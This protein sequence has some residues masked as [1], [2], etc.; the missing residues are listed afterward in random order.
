MAR[1]CTLALAVAVFLA[2][3]L[4]SAHRFGK[5]YADVKVGDAGASVI[6]DLDPDDFEPTLHQHFDRDG[7][8]RIEAAEAEAQLPL[9]GR[10]AAMG[11]SVERGGEPCQPKVNSSRVV[12]KMVRVL[13]T[14]GCAKRGALALAMP[15][16][17]RMLPGHQLLATVRLPQRVLPVVLGSQQ[18]RW[19]EGG[20][21]WQLLLRFIRMGGEHIALGFD[22]LL[23]LAALLLVAA[24][25]TDIVKIV[26]S[27]TLAH[28]I[29]LSAAALGT[30]SLPGTIVE[31]AIAASIV[32][33]AG[34]NLSES[35]LGAALRRRWLLAFVFGLVHGLGFASA[36][37]DTGL[38]KTGR[39]LALFGFNVGVE[40]G[41]L[42]VVL[43]IF[44]VLYLLRRL[45]P[46]LVVRWGSAAV[47]AVGLWWL[48]ERLVS[49]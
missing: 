13:L 48:I 44:P 47:L 29:T 3:P 27:F 4:A 31:P 37:V 5:S 18:P 32:V 8:G 21:A 2:A 26:T 36:L 11:L 46:R 38:P 17:D 12:G 34:E 41:Q 1:A 43:L 33:V 24:R 10:L 6:F 7:S 9:L 30:I 25:T 14:Y 22:H 19:S 15:L 40:L 28:S 23:F 45:Y 35:L 49:R 42:V 16:L 39:V 20:G